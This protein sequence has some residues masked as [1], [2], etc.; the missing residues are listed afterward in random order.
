MPLHNT[1]SKASEASRSQQPT[2]NEIREKTKEKLGRT[3]CE[4]QID[5]A[6]AT[7]DGRSLISIAPTGLGKTLT[8]W[9]PALFED[10][11]II[12]ITPS[13]VLGDQTAMA[14]QEAGL[15]S[16]AVVGKD[17]SPSLLQVS[18]FPIIHDGAHFTGEDILGQVKDRAS[19]DTAAAFMHINCME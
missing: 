15:T 14:A 7:L 1:T 16:V 11:I 18:K 6:Q 8:F 12:I 5:V 3:P 17:V 4:W 2:R 9:I 13:I 19:Q 10:G